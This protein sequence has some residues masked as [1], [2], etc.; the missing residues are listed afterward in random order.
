[1]VAQL[2]RLRLRLFGNLFRRGPWQVVG[3]V[4]G[5]IY[6][7]GIAVL[8]L[9]AL[10]GL[11]LF[12]DVDLL[13]DA[14]VV[15]GSLVVAGFI[16]VPLFM[17]SDDAFDPRRFALFGVP[18]RQLSFGLGVAAFVGIPAAVLAVALFGFVVTWTRG[19]GETVLAV[20]AAVLA[21]VTCIIV[22]RVTTSLASLFLSTRRA[23][24]V[25]GVIG[26]AI[27]V[28]ISPIIVLLVQI[29][30]SSSGRALL[31]SLGGILSWTPLGAAWAVP[32]GRGIR[33]VGIRDRQAPH[34]SR[35]RGPALAGLAGA[36]LARHHH[37]GSAGPVA[38]VP[39]SRLVRPDARRLHR[40]R[41]RSVA[42]VL[43][44]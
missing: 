22:A 26:V 12:P 44:P 16:V 39:R 3:V 24:E 30:W 36:G 13:R 15:A 5:L 20:L 7:F 32:G 34:R 21:L 10:V 14:L 19:F 40:C 1:M 11:R 27:L 4:V 25:S 38:R 9:F 2:L 6:G 23:R 35:H 18:D 8:C 37:A 41:G 28:L 43:D 17:G 31:R 33:F 42:D 29:D